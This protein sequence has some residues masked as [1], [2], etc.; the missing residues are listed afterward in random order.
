MVGEQ[1][2]LQTSKYENNIENEKRKM[3]NNMKEK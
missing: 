2:L 1:K 3:K